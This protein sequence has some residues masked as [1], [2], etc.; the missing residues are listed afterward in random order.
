ME[1]TGRPMSPHMTVFAFPIIAVSSGFNR[2]TGTLMS[3]GCAGFGALDIVGG[4]GTSLHLMQWVASQPWPVVAFSKFAVSFPIVYHYQGALRHFLWDFFPE[5]LN[6]EQCEQ[7][8]YIIFG[9]TAVVC[10][11]AMIM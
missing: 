10:G 4:S 11:A 2:L 1:K 9:S 6:N 8:A 5:Y 7:S 3:L